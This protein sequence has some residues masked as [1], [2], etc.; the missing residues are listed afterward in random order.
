MR[1]E[2]G[3]SLI[4]LLIVV[5][6]ILIIAAIAIP[7]FLQSRMA[8]NEALAIASC[9]TIVSAEI[10][11]NSIYNGYS[12]SLTQLG[13]SGGA[14]SSAAADLIDE[15]LV[16]GVKSGYEFTYTPGA[17]SPSTGPVN[18]ALNANP[19]TEG[20]SGNRYFFTDGSGV[21]RQNVGAAAS[22][23]DSPLD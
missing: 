3:F 16:N 17:T 11:Y 10:T 21:I 6:I 19:E 23:T 12:T 8:S 22:A 7:K 5:A 9:R 2:K 1:T 13:P 18:F 15:V 4:E 20:Q 14:T